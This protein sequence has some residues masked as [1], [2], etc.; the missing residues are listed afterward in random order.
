MQRTMLMLV[1][2]LSLAAAAAGQTAT[3]TKHTATWLSNARGNLFFR[4]SADGSQMLVNRSPSSV[5]EELVVVPSSGGEGV[6]WHTSLGRSIYDRI[7]LSGDGSTIAFA[8]T[9]ESK[10]YAVARPGAQPAL[11]ADIS[12]DSDPR[13]LRISDDGKWVAFSAA[14]MVQSGVHA[15]AHA[16]LYVAATNGAAVHRITAA[17]LPQRWIAFDLSGDGK[18]V[19]WLDDAAKGPLLADANGANA[20][21]IAITATQLGMLRC[22]TTAAHIFFDAFDSEGT[23]LWRVNHDGTGLTKLHTTTGGRFFVARASGQVRLQ[24]FDRGST[25]PGSSWL[26]TGASPTKMFELEKEDIVGTSDWS[27]DGKV[28]VWRAPASSGGSETF[29]WRAGT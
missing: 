21:R 20:R 17:A 10:I 2:L 8:K 16:N 18:S 26:Q 13:Q 15:R 7:A 28:M 23:H 11:V 22:D 5:K 4:L 6:V 19:V 27:H 3:V 24:R 25:P 9:G 29:V 1:A 14:R 12:P